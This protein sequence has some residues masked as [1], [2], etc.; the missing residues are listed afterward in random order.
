MAYFDPGFDKKRG[1]IEGA[2]FFSL[3]IPVYYFLAGKSRSIVF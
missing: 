3:L 2:P 1:A